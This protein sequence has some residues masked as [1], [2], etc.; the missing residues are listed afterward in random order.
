MN[1]HTYPYLTLPERQNKPRTVGRTMV[2][3][4]GVGLEL[5]KGVLETA[6][7][8]I[9]YYKFRSMTH[10]L[11]PEKL[12]RQKIDLLKAHQ[13]KPF[14]GGNVAELAYVQGTL[15]DH[16]AY[17]KALGWE[18]TEIS[19]T[20]IT[21][22]EEIKRELIAR[23]AK[24]GLE[25]FYEWGLKHPTQP[26]SPEAAAE[27]I[28][29]YLDMGV[30]IAIIEEGEIDML[31]GKDGK[32][33]HSNKLKRL[34]DLVGPENLMVECGALAQVSWFMREM[35]ATINLGNLNYDQTIEIEPLRRGIGRAVDYAIYQPYLKS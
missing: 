22:P 14:M 33:K 3:D 17:T 20:Y 28:Q 18:A 27:N 31:I 2:H 19:E 25:V 21:Y 8:Y 26:L 5:L 16:I 32:G 29:G 9:D 6:A 11:Y 7:P 24:A 23:S 10:A 30:S 4:S 34:F 13:I 12:T 15:D 35:G 1:V